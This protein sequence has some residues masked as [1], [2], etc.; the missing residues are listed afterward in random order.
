MGIRLPVVRYAILYRL[1]QEHKQNMQR[2]LMVRKVSEVLPVVQSEG[3]NTD[4]LAYLM[5]TP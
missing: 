1:P 5:P 2:P 4:Q 3:K